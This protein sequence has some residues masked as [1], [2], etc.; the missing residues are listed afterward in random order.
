MESNLVKYLALVEWH[1]QSLDEATRSRVMKDI[2]YDMELR[3]LR[4]GLT[5]DELVLAM[6][7]PRQLAQRYGGIDI[8]TDTGVLRRA[9]RQTGRQKVKA[10][11]EKVLDIRGFPL[12]RLLVGAAVFLL[13]LR[14]VPFLFGVI[15][16]ILGLVFS[17][18]SAAVV[19]FAFLPFLFMLVP[20]FFT[21]ITLPLRIAAAVLRAIFRPFSRW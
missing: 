8:P 19:G 12:V 17:L 18:V 1:L 7:T 15:P 16:S 2:R 11:Y 9:E 3:K 14:L 4:E 13:A 20:M 21:L 10:S 5:D 6:E